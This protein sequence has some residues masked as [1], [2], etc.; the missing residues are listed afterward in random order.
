MSNKFATM[1]TSLRAVSGDR[2]SGEQIYA[3]PSTIRVLLSHMKIEGRRHIKSWGKYLGEGCVSL[4]GRSLERSGSHVPK[5]LG[6][7]LR[8]KGIQPPNPDKR[9]KIGKS[10]GCSGVTVTKA[11]SRKGP[12]VSPQG[13]SPGN[14]EPSLARSSTQ[15]PLHGAVEEWLSNWANYK[16]SNLG[17]HGWDGVGRNLVH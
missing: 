9:W 6:L 4:V 16:S 3:F 5:S 10:L 12:S 2:I 8:R 13:N 15:G 1:P 17:M 7:G 11:A 14:G